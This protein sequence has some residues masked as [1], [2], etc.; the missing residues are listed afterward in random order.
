MNVEPEA[1]AAAAPVT[2]AAATTETEK[3][4][5]APP[6]EPEATKEEAKKEEAAAEPAKAEEKPAA[7]APKSPK[8]KQADIINQFVGWARG[9]L[10]LE[11]G[12]VGRILLRTI[13]FTLLE[14]FAVA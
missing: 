1:T 14:R 5:E 4:A 3:P 8:E 13:V 6:A 11:E 7:P 9:V 10:G 2:E 12:K